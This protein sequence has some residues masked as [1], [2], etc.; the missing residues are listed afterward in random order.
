[1]SQQLLEQYL[2]DLRKQP[3]VKEIANKL[4][5]FSNSLDGLSKVNEL[6][7]SLRSGTTGQNMVDSLIGRGKKFANALLYNQYE[8][9]PLLNRILEDYQK[10][11]ELQIKKSSNTI[12]HTILVFINN[13][14]E[15]L[16]DTINSAGKDFWK[17]LSE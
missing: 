9:N 11:P 1:M 12:N 14:I 16:S 6:I 7:K 17:K 2:T 4:E 3:D 15:V 10:D 8:D 13:I 5:E